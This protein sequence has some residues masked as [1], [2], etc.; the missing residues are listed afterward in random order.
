MTIDVIILSKAESGMFKNMTETAI[1]SVVASSNQIH[2]NIVV[3][4]G[5]K[6][7]TYRNAQ[8][9]YPDEPF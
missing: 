6:G 8:T 2:F 4:E 1:N 9:V 3:V 7:I 5:I